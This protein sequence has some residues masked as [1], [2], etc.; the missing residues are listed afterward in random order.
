MD[1]SNK[2]WEN[3][4][5]PMLLL[6]MAPS[7]SCW[8]L[9]WIFFTTGRGISIPL[10]IDIR[11]LK[12]TRRDRDLEEKLLQNVSFVLT[13]NEEGENEIQWKYGDVFIGEDGSWVDSLST[14]FLPKC[15]VPG[16]VGRELNMYPMHVRESQ[17]L[18]PLGLI[19]SSFNNRICT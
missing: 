8:G 14:R 1:L 10:D 17:R 15:F 7:P 9:A 5:L 13:R 4:Y 18:L 16:N 3:V 11:L 2:R 19:S 12:E 6:T